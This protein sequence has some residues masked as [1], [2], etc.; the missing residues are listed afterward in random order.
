M[1][2]INVR[3][4]EQCNTKQNTARS[5]QQDQEDN[6][7][8]GVLCSCADPVERPSRRVESFGQSLNFYGMVVNYGCCK[9]L[10]K[11]AQNNKKQQQRD[12]IKTI[13]QMM[14]LT[15]RWLSLFAAGSLNR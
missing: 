6:R 12:F 5:A 1:V 8:Q 14:A 9:V 3:V 10:T 11:T 4:A 7:R 2:G 13:N 15:R